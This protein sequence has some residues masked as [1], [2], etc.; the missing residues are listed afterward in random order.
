MKRRLL[1][2][3]LLLGLLVTTGSIAGQAEKQAA[4]KA[5]ETAPP[6]DF[7]ALMHKIWAAWET[8]D[9]AKAAPFYSK[10]TGR[11]FY[12]VAPLKYTGWREY[13]E[14]VVKV[15]SDYT[16]A[17]FT[18]GNDAQAHRHGNLAWGTATWHG[19][20]LKKDGGKDIFDGRWTVVW[21]KRGDDWLIVHEHVSV[22]LPP[23]P[24][25]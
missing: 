13:A 11:V 6:Y 23:P 12:D 8:L 3:P 22:P 10:N 15:M 16:S 1:F 4:K 25:K 18:L 9:P 2:V 5:A 21:E 7:K 14:G 20:L 17:K 24:N 19:E